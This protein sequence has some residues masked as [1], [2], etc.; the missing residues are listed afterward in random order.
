MQLK[1]FLGAIGFYRKFVKDYAK[2][3]TP[4][5]K[6]LKKDKKLTLMMQSIF[7]LSKF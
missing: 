4:M 7:K 2:I 6:Y 5:I 3:A 1:G